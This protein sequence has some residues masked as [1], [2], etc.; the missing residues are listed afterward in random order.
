MQDDI[1]TIVIVS[2]AVV[3][4]YIYSAI[5]FQRIAI[6]SNTEPSWHA[7][8]PIANLF[9]L[10]KL[11]RSSSWWI[12]LCLI[13]YLGFIFSLILLSRV[14]KCLGVTDGSRFLMLVPLVNLVY[15]GYLAFRP[16][17]QA[18]VSPNAV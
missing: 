14:P 15:L 3:C 11:A 7:W 1:S 17:L 13:P 10:C 12:L 2:I 6:K 4:F 8:V 18:T 9:L 5:C 16:E